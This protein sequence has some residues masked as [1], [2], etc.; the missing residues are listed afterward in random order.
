MN[1]RKVDYTLCLQKT[2]PPRARF[3]MFKMSKLCTIAI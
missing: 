1:Q 3:K 2:P